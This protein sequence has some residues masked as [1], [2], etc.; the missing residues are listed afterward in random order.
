MNKAKNKFL[1]VFLLVLFFLYSLYCFHNYF[2]TPISDF[3]DIRESTISLLNLSL[4]QS[5]KRVPLYPLLI[6]ILS[7]FFPFVKYPILFAAQLLNLILA[8]ISLLLI[9]L[10]S[11]KFLN[12][13][14]FVV[15]WLC[16]LNINTLFST[17]QP[18]IEMTLLTTILLSIYL[19]IKGSRLV[20]LA[21]AL[22]ALTRYEAALLIP[23][24][25]GYNLIYQKKRLITLLFGL[26]SSLGIIIWI[27]LS[28]IHS[29]FINPYV[30]EISGMGLFSSKFLFIND[31]MYSLINWASSL[32][33]FIPIFLLFIFIGIYSLIKDSF[34][35]F[36]PTLLFFISYIIIHI[37]Y[38]HSFPRFAFPITWVFYLSL[39]KGVEYS[40]PLIAKYQKRNPSPIFLKFG[41]IV[42]FLALLFD[43]ISILKELD[44][45]IWIFL[46]CTLPIFYYLNHL[47]KGDKNKK[48]FL[49]LLSSLFFLCFTRESIFFTLKVMEEQKYHRIEF[50]QVGEW[51][52][53]NLKEGEKL[54]TT[55]P[56]IV[57]FYAELPKEQFISLG[58]FKDKKNFISELREKKVTY[59][60]WD[61]TW[62][63]VNIHAYQDGKYKI[64]YPGGWYYYIIFKPYL[65][66]HLKDGKNTPHF[67]L[68]KIIKI[69]THTALIYKFIS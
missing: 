17:I 36:L 40:I 43:N 44:K 45:N 16:A 57:S 18:L 33:S 37:A 39:V 68:I 5:F 6:G 26:L 56:G 19:A 10:I 11:N 28:Y 67:K 1:L 64:S 35:E 42:F 47:F 25:V 2:Y 61:S 29:Q 38:P 7:L 54:V 15:V 22:A 60:V 3:F 52:K 4:P 66:F 49:F 8:I 34:R 50:R 46:G 58:S 14:A 51:C 13:G 69:N 12:K 63:K 20:Y 31:C 55:E 21:L 32:F 27:G 65:I 30:E 48:I 62:C 23:I 9:Y 24:I 59:V 53:I 41:S